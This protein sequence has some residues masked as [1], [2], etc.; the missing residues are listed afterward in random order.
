MQAELSEPEEAV[1]DQGIVRCSVECSASA[2]SSFQVH[3]AGYV[4]SNAQ[5]W[6]LQPATP[7]RG[8]EHQLILLQWLLPDKQ[9]HRDNLWPAC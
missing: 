6:L 7:S 1:P 9:H 4:H 5:L 8:P 3:T 2:S